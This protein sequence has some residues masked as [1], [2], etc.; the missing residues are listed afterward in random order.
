MLQSGGAAVICPGRISV[1]DPVGYIDFLRLMSGVR[2]VLSDYRSGTARL[3]RAL[4]ASCM[5]D[6]EIAPDPPASSTGADPA[7]SAS[8]ANAPLGPVTVVAYGGEREEWDAFVRR[9][10][11]GTF[12]HLTGWKDVLES[13]FNF[14]PHYLLARRNG[15]LVGVLPL[16][17]LRPPFSGR[18]LLSVPF[19]VEGGVCSADMQARVAL[20]EA[21][22]SQARAMRARYLEL[23]DGLEGGGFQ[24]R[25]GVYYRFR[26]QLGDTDEENLAAIPRKQRR[27]VRVGQ[28]SGL[29]ARVSNDD[30]SV[31]FD[32]YARS[33]RHLGTPVFGQ[34]Y[35]RSLLERFPRDS[36]LLTVWHGDQ[37]AAAV[38]S[39]FFNDTVLPYYAGSRH[40]LFRYA[41]NDF[42]Y[43]ELTRYART[44]GARVFDFGRSKKGTGA[45]DF[46][47]HWGFEPEPL[48]YRIYAPG[49]T[50]TRGHT[51]NDAHVQILRH[52]WQRLPL[53][54][55]KF[56]G[57][58]VIRTYGASY[59]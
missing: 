43:W 1:L 4:S 46:K 54:V 21:A 5:T 12:F 58:Y 19:A 15:K 3:P 39:F 36:V 50:P 37:P 51:A 31:F 32:L 33:V 24:M 18:R 26:R 16:F 27:M 35:F 38:L 11:G 45:Y 8:A 52:V 53:G 56:L 7:A 48:R 25:E 29:V 6:C 22:C 2:L 40:E 47:C 14:T 57:P 10:P 42:M 20:E 49:G 23:R 13:T 9:T 55:T 34:H 59:T 17:E 44:R 30:V 28:Q 41:I